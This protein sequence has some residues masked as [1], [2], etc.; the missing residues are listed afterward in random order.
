LDHALGLELENAPAF[1]KICPP[2]EML[3]SLR[4]RFVKS[5]ICGSESDTMSYS[6]RSPSPILVIAFQ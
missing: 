2:P 6:S 4:M 5:R 1:N 3:G